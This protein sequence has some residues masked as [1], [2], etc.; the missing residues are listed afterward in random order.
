MTSIP[1]LSRPTDWNN[2][3]DAIIVMEFKPEWISILGFFAGFIS[4]GFCIFGVTNLDS[5][6]IPLADWTNNFD[7]IFDFEIFYLVMNMNL[8]GANNSIWAKSSF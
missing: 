3:L 7:L 1:G 5:R 2:S 6:F 8:E 4:A